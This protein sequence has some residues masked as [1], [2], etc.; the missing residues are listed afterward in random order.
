M[1][2]RG[3]GKTT[4]VLS[5]SKGMLYIPADNPLV[6]PFPL[7]D[8][9]EAAFGAGYN[10]I[11]V[12]E[13]HYARE[14]PVH[15]KALYDA[16]PGRN[17]WATDSSS[18]SPESGISD[19]S[20]RFVKIKIPLLSF[21]EFIALKSDRLFP[22]IDPSNPGMSAVRDVINAINPPGGL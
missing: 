21:R 6:A 16:F 3:V 15:L 12:D 22:A 19:L 8:I 9:A 2:P 13:A 4:L 1:G 17:I 7:W 14:W 11:I 5:R 20:R 18:A 10:G